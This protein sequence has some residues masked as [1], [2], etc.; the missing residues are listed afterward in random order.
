MSTVLLF[1][2]LDKI[3]QTPKG[4]EVQNLLVHLTDSVQNSEFEDKYLA[5][6][7]IDLSKV[8]FVF[9]AND[10]NKID[11]ILLDRMLVVKLGGYQPKDKLVIAEQYLLPSI[12]KEVNLA[13]KVSISKEIM[14]YIIETYAKEEDGVREMKRCIESIV[15][16]INMLR[17]YNDKSLPFYIKDFSLPFVVKKEH[18]DL[19]LKKKDAS[20]QAPFGMYV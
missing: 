14:A 1:D 8:M 13:E 2:E 16:K 15:Q 7:P 10:I 4:E 18:I 17:M 12:L 5:G 20:A 19:F 3:S 6:I 11:R 9:S